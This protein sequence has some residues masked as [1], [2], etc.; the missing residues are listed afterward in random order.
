MHLLLPNY[1]KM[2]RR[3]EGNWM[4]GKGESPSTP[5]VFTMLLKQG[6][7]TYCFFSAVR[8]L[9]NQSVSTEL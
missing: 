5:C 2:Y 3:R 1:V 9:H 7:I 8:L 4:P 6:Q